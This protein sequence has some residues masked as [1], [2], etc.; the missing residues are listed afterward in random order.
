MVDFRVE[1]SL[2]SKKQWIYNWFNA[3]ID[4][5]FEDLVEDPE[6]KYCFITL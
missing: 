3:G 2:L 5:P 1:L 4:K 6:Q